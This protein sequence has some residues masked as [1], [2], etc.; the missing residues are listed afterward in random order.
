MANLI[1]CTRLSRSSV[2]VLLV[3]LASSTT[4]MAQAPAPTA[5]A[6]SDNA[7]SQDLEEIVVTGNAAHGGLKKLD[8]SYSVTTLSDEEIKEAN[9]T[10]ANDLLKASPGVH[11]ESSGG[12]SGANIEVAGFPGSSGSPYVTVALNGAPAFP[13]A[14]LAYL[15]QG[16]LLRLDDTIERTELVQGGPSVLYGNAQPGLFANF[17]LKRG[18]VTPTGDVGITYGSEGLVRLDGFGSFPI[19]AG[20]GWF[21]S[22]GGFWRESDGT[23]DPQY[24][25]DLGG[26]LTATLT[27]EWDEGSLMLYSRYL[28]D[29][30]QFVTDTPILNPSAGNFS[31]YPGFSPLTGTMGSKADQYEFLQTTPCS[32]P[33][34]KPSGIAIDMA[35]GRGPVAQFSGADFDW[36][37]GNG[38]TLSDKFGF[39]S[40]TESMVAFYSGGTNPTSLASYI[41]NAETADKLPAGLVAT[42]T[43]ANNGTAAS[44]TQNVLTQEL[45]DVHLNFQATSNEV[46]VSDELF[47]GNTLTVGNYTTFYSAD[48]LAIQGSDIL[49]QAQSNPDPIAIGLTNGT[50]TW[51]LASPE[52][53]TTGPTTANDTT[54]TGLNTALI[55][56]DSW[57]LGQW[58][59]DAGIRE[60]HQHVTA[61]LGNAA[62]GDLDNDPYTLYNN[63][64]RYLVAGQ[65]NIYFSKTVPSWTAG[66]NYAFTPNM[67]AYARVNDGVHFPSITDLT[68]NAATPVEQIH[69]ME[70]G[71]KY[72][73]EWVYT[74]LSAFRR[75][76]YGVPV[77]GLTVAVG[78]TTEAVSYTYGSQANGLDFQTVVK[79]FENFS[80]GLSGDY[81]DSHYTHSSG[82]FTFQGATTQTACNPSNS[83]D[84]KQLA[85]QPDIQFRLTPAYTLPTSWGSLRAWVTYEFIGNH[86]G[87]QLEEQP[88][89]HYYDLAFGVVAD[90]GKNWEFRVQGT[91]VTNQIGITEGN[92]RVLIGSGNTGGVVLAR[93]IEGSEVNIQAKYK[94]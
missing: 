8:V 29:K 4:A 55:L 54:G 87:D 20:S 14:G 78:N 40:G 91:N 35:N 63:K 9:T 94:F 66:V 24:K 46:H 34:C 12:Q 23:R 10:S 5:P 45:R 75:L 48:L 16:S 21:G 30:N 73:N 11:V 27:R 72:E 22:I 17:I 50:N 43:Y 52:G 93:S 64:S 92:A 74:T 28:N 47:P 61:H 82:C 41:A 57:K 15:E 86:F 89:G 25:A 3:A 79:L 38:W 26:Q 37:F 84:G 19:G 56:S 32:T 76:F 39:S 71:F 18:T 42:A 65:S 69:N 51:Q 33:G 62:T 1:V 81:Q 83:F 58:L 70:V 68:S 53:F 80:V 44:M 88:L 90:V 2:I 67:S 49:L 6:T 77:S 59:F 7:A 31:A 60:E 13:Q 36:D 85:R